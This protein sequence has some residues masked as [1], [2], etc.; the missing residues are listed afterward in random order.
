M[1]LLGMNRRMRLELVV[2]GFLIPVVLGC[3]ASAQRPGT[4]S[5]PTRD[6]VRTINRQEMDAMLLRKKL[7][8][9]TDAPARRLL[10]KQI[11]D[12]FRALQNLNNRM[13]SETWAR[14]TVDYE[15]VSNM[16]S[17]I[18]GKATR[19]KSNLNL[20]EPPKLQSEPRQKPTNEAEFRAA[21]LTLDQTIMRFINNPVFQAANTIDVD[22]ATQARRD[23]ET[24]IDL[25]ESLRKATSR[26]GNR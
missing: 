10:L 6:M 18:K 4:P 19:L 26:L 9:T 3:A 24:V 21:L 23:L 20:P 12:D 25:A 1:H 11:N 15:F 13:M 2:S 22:Y 8:S 7:P 16:I 14:E 17:Q 5:N